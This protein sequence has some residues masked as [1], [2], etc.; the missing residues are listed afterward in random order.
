MYCLRCGCLLPVDAKEPFCRYCRLQIAREEV[1]NDPT[2]AM[3]I[4]LEALGQ[5]LTDIMRELKTLKSQN[6]PVR[7]NK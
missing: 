3:R 4:A 2:W 5:E 1:A 7:T 6:M